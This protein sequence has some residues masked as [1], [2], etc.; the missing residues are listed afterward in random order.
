MPSPVSRLRAAR[1]FLIDMDGTLYVGERLL[2]GARELLA[3]LTAAGRPF[4]LLSNNSSARASHYH[5]RLARLGVDVP[6]ERVFTSSEAMADYLLQRTPYRA[7]YVI[8]TPAFEAVLREAGLAVSPRE[9]DCVVV[10][11]DTTLTYD[12]LS[13]GCRFLWAGL[14]Y[15]A[16]HPDYTCITETGLVPDIR[17]ILA[18]L[19]ELTGRWPEIVGKPEPP[20]VD[21]ALGRVATRASETAMIGDQLDTDM[22]MARR[23]G[24]LSVLVMTGETT[25]EKLRAE[26]ATID[27]TVS[28]VHEV[29]RL[30]TASH[31]PSMP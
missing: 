7:P 12:K 6:A 10:G 9:P 11:F 21:M 22:T 19:R 4:L 26:S 16:T 14:P 13:L 30:L 1:A 3:Y 8:G 29:L 20:M 15:F 31:E 23:A 17:V 28:G 27:L 2:P 18:G 25:V 24:L 5:R